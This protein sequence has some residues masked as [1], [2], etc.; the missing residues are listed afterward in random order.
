MIDAQCA[1]HMRS[2]L[3]EG[4]VWHPGQSRLYWLDLRRPA[5]YRFDPGSGANEQ[6]QAEL[7][8]YVG[9][10]VFRAD[11]SMVVNNR[12]GI[13]AVDIASGK[14]TALADPEPDKPENWF[15]D[16]KCDRLGRLWAGTGDSNETVASGNL[17]V[18]EHDHSWR[19]V[20]RNIIC[21]NG[22]AFSP[23]GRSAYF[24]DSY[25]QEVVRYEIDPVTGEIGERRPFLKITER[26]VYP[27]GLTVDAEGGV[28]VAEW[29]AWR[30]ARYTPDGT[31]DREIRL[32][33]PRPT[34]MAFGGD[35]LRTLYITTASIGLSEAQLR[36]AP[37][38]GSLFECHP[39]VAGLPE[40]AY[41]G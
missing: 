36:E 1:L 26:E 19:V 41:V 39:G 31:F 38:S 7:G 8:D 13:H 35:D 9:G 2:I 32:P 16:A 17:Y 33:V 4:P 6:I 14:L 40:P 29:D 15:N 18:F 25:A 20:D 5:I 28:W 27:D 3:G 21:S 30:V 34:S 37:L 10:L 12:N 22:P 23:D 11:G 24:S